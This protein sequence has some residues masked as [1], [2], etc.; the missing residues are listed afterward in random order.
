MKQWDT[1]AIVGVGLIGGSIGM[2][3]RQRNLAKSVVGIGR[4]Q[5]GLRVARRV[6]A[7]THTTIDLAKGVADAELVIV[8]TPVS[9]LV[10]QVREAAKHCRQR[11]LITD[12]GSAKQQVV[13]SLDGDLPNGCRFLGGHPLAGSEKTGAQHASADLFEGRVAVL[14]PTKNTCAEDFDQ[15]A[16]FW[17]A[18]GA[19][20][21]KM[22]PEE[23]DQA[24]AMTSHLPHLAAAILALT[25]PEKLFRL[26]GRGI[27]DTTRVAASD[28]ELWRQVLA[29]NRDNVLTALE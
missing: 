22:S 29:M 9:R 4:G 1:V 25:V 12:T 24:L 7:V 28:P 18:L 19:V 5:P 16:D 11:T 26:C 15:L 10:E 17:Q 8:C 6:G 27:Q 13:E 3:V 23:H 20:V 2:A 14:T 21:V